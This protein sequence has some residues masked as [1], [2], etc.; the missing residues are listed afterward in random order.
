MTK[1]LDQVPDFANLSLHRI[2]LEYPMRRADQEGAAG[3]AWMIQPQRPSQNA[4]LGTWLVHAPNAHPFWEWWMVAVVHL[5]EGEDLP[6]PKHIY[7][8]AEYEFTILTVDDD[9]CPNPDPELVE[10][11]G[12]LFYTPP[13][14]VEQFHGVTDQEAMSIAGMAVTSIVD[15]NMSPDPQ[16]RPKWKIMLEETVK[17][18]QDGFQTLN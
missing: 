3:R 14:V 5:R 16:Y 7:A 12:L 4:S 17:S 10:E 8:G 9:E 2:G 13:D 11:E 15:G 6:P 18:F 1:P